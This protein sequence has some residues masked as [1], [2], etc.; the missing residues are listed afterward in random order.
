MRTKYEGSTESLDKML[1]N[2][3]H[4]K[5][6]NG[7]GFEEGQSSNNKD[8]FSKEIQFTSSSES[9]EKQTLTVNKDTGKKTYI[10]GAR[11][12]PM[13]Q[14]APPMYQNADHKG[15]FKSDDE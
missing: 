12:H 9:K 8:I 7:L 2:Q 11:N 13:N 14:Y 3:K 4:S 1:N 5:D 15:R 6:T 10:E